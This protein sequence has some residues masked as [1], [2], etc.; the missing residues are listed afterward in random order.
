MQEQPQPNAPLVGVK[1]PPR[2][3]V[4][5]DWQNAAYAVQW[6]LFGVFAI[7]WFGR[8]V[9]VET[10]ERRRAAPVPVHADGLDRMDAS[11][12]LPREKGAP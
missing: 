1:P 7:F 12:G 10:D 5:T 9:W 3:G 6:W 8:V 2:V 11:D 4:V